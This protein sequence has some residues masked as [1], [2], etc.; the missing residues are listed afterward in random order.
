MGTGCLTLTR[1]LTLTL[2]RQG[3]VGGPKVRAESARIPGRR[4]HWCG[5]P[6]GNAS[7]GGGAQSVLSECSPQSSSP[8]T[9]KA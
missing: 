1:S 7:S 5:G 6:P 2:P 8:H 9:L 3:E 4:Q